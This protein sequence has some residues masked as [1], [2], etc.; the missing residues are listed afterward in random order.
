MNNLVQDNAIFKFKYSPVE[1]V[2]DTDVFIQLVTEYSLTSPSQRTNIDQ[3]I[4]LLLEVHSR[5]Y[6]SLESVKEKISNKFLLNYLD[7]VFEEAKDAGVE[8]LKHLQVWIQGAHDNLNY[9]YTQLDEH[10]HFDSWVSVPGVVNTHTVI[11]PLF[12]NSSITE[13]FWANWIENIEQTVT[14]KLKILMSMDVKKIDKIVMQ[15]AFKEWWAKLKEVESTNRVKIRFPDMG[16]KLTLDFN[17]RN[18]LHGITG[19]GSNL[20]LIIVFDKWVTQ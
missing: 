17:S 8:Q 1:V 18:F 20:Y 16:E 15:T 19:V 14:S 4:D 12:I 10:T 5:E 2:N 11:I 6:I 7:P 3:K 13:S 9:P